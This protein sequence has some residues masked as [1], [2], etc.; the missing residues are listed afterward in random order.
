MCLVSE[1]SKK[2]LTLPQKQLNLINIKFS[3]IITGKICKNQEVIIVTKGNNG[4]PL[5]HKNKR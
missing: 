2:E 1:G 3:R 4:K 5:N